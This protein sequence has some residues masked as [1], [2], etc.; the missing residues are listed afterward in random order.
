MKANPREQ[1]GRAQTTEEDPVLTQ[2]KEGPALIK[3][4]DLSQRGKLEGPTLAQEKDLALT[5]EKGV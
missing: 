3:E 5:M 4:T 2:A 1:V